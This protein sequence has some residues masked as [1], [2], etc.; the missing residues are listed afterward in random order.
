MYLKTCHVGRCLSLNEWLSDPRRN[1]DPRLRLEVSI[2]IELE[3]EPVNYCK[4]Q[5]KEITEIG[6]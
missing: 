3:V 2:T 4:G 1:A 5:S 6:H